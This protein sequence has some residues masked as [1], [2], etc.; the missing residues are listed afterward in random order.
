MIVATELCQLASTWAGSLPPGGLA[1]EEKR[2]GWRALFM[3]NHAGEPCLFTRGGMRIEGADHII[4]RCRLLERVAGQPLVIDGEFQ[5]DGSL[6][7]TKRWCEAGWR[8]G[9]EAGVLHAFDIVPMVNWVRGEWEW[10]WHRRKAWL[11][12]LSRQVDADPGLSW[13]W[14]PGSRGADDGR[15]AVRVLPDGWVFTL[16]DVLDEA[17]R[18]WGR[19]G[20]G[21]VLKDPIAPYQR[22]R[23]DAWLKVRRDTPA[24]C[25]LL[26]E[27]L[28][29]E[30]RKET[31]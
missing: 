3:R 8:R 25:K 18:V 4:H 12:S 6:E 7:A 15:D 26:R 9:G 30:R 19:D 16:P 24:V 23:S 21:L 11:V 20:E 17:R 5:V 10:P 1:F 22:K 27:G 2:N 31:K 14:R 28:P 29:V 13:E